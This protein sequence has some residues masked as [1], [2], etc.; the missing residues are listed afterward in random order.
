MI[1]RNENFKTNPEDRT[2]KWTLLY[3]YTWIF[4]TRSRNLHITNHGHKCEVFVLA[5]LG[6]H[7]RKSDVVLETFLF[8]PKLWW[9]SLVTLRV[10]F[11]QKADAHDC[12]FLAKER[13]VRM[14]Q[15]I[16]AEQTWKDVVA[17]Q[18]HSEISWSAVNLC[19]HSRGGEAYE[20]NRFIFALFFN[21]L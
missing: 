15:Q 6:Y 19:V 17:Y 9:T 13:T 5:L 20:H 16:S 8:T 21:Y 14:I 3:W 12:L 10:H 11:T 4:E 2:R 1:W 7:L 18:R